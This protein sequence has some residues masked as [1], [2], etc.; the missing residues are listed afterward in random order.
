MQQRFVDKV[1]LI[2]GASEGIGAAAA[3]AFAREGARL[4]LAARSLARL[5]EVAARC[6]AAR[7][8]RG[9][10]GAHLHTPVTYILR[11]R[12]MVTRPEGCG[13]A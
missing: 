5:E 6:R 8:L 13:C 12:C 10:A 3:V 1:V 9:S 2:T 11:S 4:V 7:S